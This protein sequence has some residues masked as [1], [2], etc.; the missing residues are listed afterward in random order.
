L[1]SESR[2]DRNL[3]VESCIRDEGR[4]FEARL[5]E[6]ELQ[7]SKAV[8]SE[9]LRLSVERKSWAGKNQKGEQT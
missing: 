1:S 3:T 4:S 5:Q 9:H 8:G 7:Q 6:L 2:I